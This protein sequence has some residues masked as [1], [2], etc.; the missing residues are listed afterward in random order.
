MGGGGKKPRKAKKNRTKKIR[1]SKK[2]KITVAR[3]IA[4]VSILAPVLK[5]KI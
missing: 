1:A 5:C 4:R 3:V 2:F